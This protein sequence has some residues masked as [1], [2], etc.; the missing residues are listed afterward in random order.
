MEL[1]IANS[2]YTAQELS[3]LGY[4]NL[5]VVP[6]VYLDDKCEMPPDKA[7][8]ERFADG[9]TNLLFVSRIVP[10]KK[11]EDIIKIFRYYRSINPDSRLLLVGSLG[12]TRDYYRWLLDLVD[13]LSLP[14]VHFTDRVSPEELNA[15]YRLADVF[16]SMSEHEGFGVFLVESMYFGLPVVA[17]K[18]AAV[19]EILGDAGVLIKEKDFPII[20][21]V[22]HLLVSDPDLRQAIL[23]TQRERIKDFAREKV[24]AQFWES[25]APLLER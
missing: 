23:E 10:N 1:A 19:P 24:E 18:S 22:I 7:T 14:D 16:V 3:T 5:A 9:K 6:P 12:E 17:Y 25:L 15:Y 8:L 11:Q 20:A 13:Y 2:S 4:S 21:E